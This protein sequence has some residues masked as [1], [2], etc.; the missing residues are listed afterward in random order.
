VFLISKNDVANTG[1]DFMMAAFYIG[2][3]YFIVNAVAIAV[4]NITG[5]GLIVANILPTI[6]AIVVIMKLMGKI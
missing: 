3:V 5:T 4:F 1:R 2:L 6:F